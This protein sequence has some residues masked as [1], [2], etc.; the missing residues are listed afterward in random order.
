AHVPYPKYVFERIET[1]TII[2]S[3]SH[4]DFVPDR[5]ER[6]M[7]T[8]PPA[9]APWRMWFDELWGRVQHKALIAHVDPV[10]LQKGA[11]LKLSL[12]PGSGAPSGVPL[13]AQLSVG[14][15]QETNFWL[16]PEPGVMVTHRLAPGLQTVRAVQVETNGTVWFSDVKSLTAVSGQTN[17][18]VV[19]LQRGVAVHGQLDGTVPRPVRNGRVVAHVWPSGLRPQD[20][21]PQ[22]HAWTTNRE[23]GSFDFVSLPPGDLEIVV[24]CDGFVSTNTPGASSMHYPQKHRLG[25]NDLAVMI[26]M[27]PTA[28]LE[29]MVTDDKG[30]P[31]KGAHVGTWPNVQYGAWAATILAGDRYNMAELLVPR[32]ATDFGY[33]SKPVSDFEGTTDGSG[34]AVL[35]NLPKEVKEFNVEHDQFILPAAVAVGGQKRREAT[36]SLK[37]G[38]TNHA[39]VALEPKGRSAIAHY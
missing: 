25:T 6:V 2:C 17:E 27:E 32:T 31:L 12:R 14:R 7:A 11:T 5:P 38:Q 22:W 18:L 34:V 9:G 19:D 10:V 4:P 36:V 3:F 15:D 16:R 28:R 35:A 24:L 23:D 39:S 29:V 33:W 37:A 21:P 1:G 26:G 20:S 30:K 13:Y 8:A